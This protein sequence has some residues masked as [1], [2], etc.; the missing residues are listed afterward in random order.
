MAPP[1]ATYRPPVLSSLDELLSLGRSKCQLGLPHFNGSGVVELAG[2]ISNLL[3]QDI[4][5]VRYHVTDIA[6]M[7]MTHQ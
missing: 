7:I 5:T 1:M 6:W 2:K 3:E 4:P